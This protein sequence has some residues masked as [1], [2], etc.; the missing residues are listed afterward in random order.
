MKAG[1]NIKGNIKIQCRWYASGF[2]SL[3][4]TFIKTMDHLL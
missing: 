2:I 1:S 3:D 4:D